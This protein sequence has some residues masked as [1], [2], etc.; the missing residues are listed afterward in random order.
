MRMGEVGMESK[1][2]PHH[3]C[4]GDTFTK[5]MFSVNKGVRDCV[6]IYS[7]LY[8]ICTENVVSFPRTIKSYK[9]NT[10]TT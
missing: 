3:S 5:E 4:L 10:G 8:D 1:D 6:H 9:Q 7:Y 2:Q